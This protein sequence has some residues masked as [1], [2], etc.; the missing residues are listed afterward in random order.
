MAIYSN[1]TGISIEFLPKQFHATTYAKALIFLS[2]LSDRSVALCLTWKIIKQVWWL[3]VIF[4]PKTLWTLINQA[5]INYILIQPLSSVNFPLYKSLRRMFD[6]DLVISFH[7]LFM[8]HAPLL[9]LGCVETPLTPCGICYAS[10]FLG[11][12]LSSL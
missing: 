9:G 1:M 6:L 5:S 8:T 3:I 11:H 4:E 10:C 12:L 2:T 7:S